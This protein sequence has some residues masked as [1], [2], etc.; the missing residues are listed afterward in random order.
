MVELKVKKRLHSA[1]GEMQLSVE[2]SLN[3]GEF[4][5]I[6]G[7]SGVGKTTILRILA[8]LCEPDEGYIEVD[9]KTWFDSEKGVNLPP[10]KRGIGFVF[11]D[12][13]LFPNMTVEENLRFALKKGESEEVVDELMDLVELR[14]LAKRLPS[15]LSGGQ[16]Q[17]VA[18]ARALV[19]RPSL[20][21]LDEPL[22]ALDHTM[23]SKLQEELSKL[24]ERFSLTTLLVSHDPSEIFRL[25]SRVVRIEQGRVVKDGTPSE[26]FI[27]ERIGS[28]F[29]FVGEVL[30]IDRCDM[31]Y[32]LTVAVGGQIVK[33]V[34]SKS[35]REGLRVG[36]RIQIV[37]KSFNPMILKIDS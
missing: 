18:V 13:A 36:S 5:S 20:L 32:T 26:L 24:H 21:L 12:Y 8:G 11:Q 16:R 23:R 34:A 29:K 3:R 19:Q 28:S 10:Q 25:C 1:A 6:F 9:G 30:E 15:E 2:L 33:V 17:R 7:E 31:L 4:V 37:S 14:A 22:S 35:E 27:K